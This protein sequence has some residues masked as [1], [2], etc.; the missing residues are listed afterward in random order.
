MDVDEAKLELEMA[1]RNLQGCEGHLQRAAA[2]WMDA[3]A[4]RGSNERHYRLRRRYGDNYL[5]QLTEEWESAR[6]QFKEA[7][8]RLNKA[9]EEY[10][11]A[12]AA[13]DC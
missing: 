12:V 13:N 2:K 3:K 9:R 7:T 4:A 1:S 11:K 8:T 5:Q 6:E 10:D